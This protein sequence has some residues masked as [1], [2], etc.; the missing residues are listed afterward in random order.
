MK[1]SA[2]MSLVLSILH[3]R[4]KNLLLPRY[5]YRTHREIWA[6]ATDMEWTC[7]K[8]FFCHWTE[9][10][11]QVPW[12]VDVKSQSLRVFLH[13]EWGWGRVGK[14]CGAR[15]GSWLLSMM[16]APRFHCIIFP[17]NW[18]TRVTTSPLCNLYAC[19]TPSAL[20]PF[21][22][23]EL[24]KSLS[25]SSGSSGPWSNHSNFSSALAPYWE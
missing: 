2:V 9:F 21:P 6:E 23:Q 24:G 18:L 10:L 4:L 25:H 13:Q 20:F 15:K 5:K 19:T 3:L 14:L 8:Y 22:T 12:V 17:D 7:K 16:L 11:L 1:Q